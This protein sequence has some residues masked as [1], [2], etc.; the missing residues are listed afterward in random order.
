MQLNKATST[1]K[2]MRRIS[3]QDPFLFL[4]LFLFL[5]FFFLF[6][7]FLFLFLFWLKSHS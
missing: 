5:F 3:T 1:E 7:F 4:F 6:F 2:R